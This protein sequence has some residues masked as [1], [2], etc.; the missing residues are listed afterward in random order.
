MLRYD[1]VTT[2]LDEEKCDSTKEVF[3]VGCWS[4]AY[5]LQEGLV[6]VYLRQLCEGEDIYFQWCSS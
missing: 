1:A 3:G 5:S 4:V 2:L 6:D